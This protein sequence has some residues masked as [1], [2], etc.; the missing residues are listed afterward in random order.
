MIYPA[1]MISALQ[2]IYASRMKGT[3]I[4]SYLR[5]KYIIWLVLLHRIQEKRWNK[6]GTDVYDDIKSRSN[7]VAYISDEFTRDGV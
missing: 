1:C 2:M 4:I 3:D 6:K 7:K 5:S